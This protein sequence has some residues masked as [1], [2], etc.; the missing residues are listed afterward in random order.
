MNAVSPISLTDLVPALRWSKSPD[1]TAVLRHPRLVDGWWRSL[2]LPRVLDI[3]GPTWLAHCLARLSVEQWDHLEVCEFVPT[4]RGL[5]VDLAEIAEPVR[6][7]VQSTAGDWER[8]VHASPRTMRS[9]DFPNNCD[10]LEVVGTVMWQSILPFTGGPLNG[11]AP[12]PALVIE[13]VRTIANWM[14][15]SAPDHVRNAMAYLTEATGADSAGPTTDSVKGTQSP[16]TRAIRTLR[17]LR[18]QRDR[19]LA[20]EEDGAASPS[21]SP[22]PDP[23]EPVPLLAR[24][25]GSPLL[26]PGGTLRRPAF[27]PPKALR[28][29]S[30]E[31]AASAKADTSTNAPELGT[32]PLIDLFEQLCREWNDLERL[33]AT[34]RLFTAEPTSIRLL[35]DQLQMD[36]GAL[37]AAQRTVEE[38][39]LQWLNSPVGAPLAKHL[40][41]VSDQ[42]G[43]ATTIDLLVNAHPDHPVDVPSLGIP[44]WQIV[45]TLFTDRRLDDNWLLATD[46]GYLRR[47]T[48]QLLADQPSL[49]EAGTRL[50]RL[51]IRPQALRAWLLSTPGVSLQDGRVL[52]DESV[53]LNAAEPAG[54]YGGHTAF[55][56]APQTTTNGLPIRRRPAESKAAA[57]SKPSVAASARCFRAPDGRWWHRVDVT[58]DQLNGAPVAVPPGY[59]AHLGL[60]PGRLLCL[61]GPGADLLVLVWRDQAAF[62]SLRPLLRRLGAQPGDRLF[63]TVNGD[64]LDS[65]LLQ[66]SAVPADSGPLGLALSLTG[67]TAQATPEEALDIIARRISEADEGFTGT[68]AELLNLL[69]SRGD[70]DIAEQLRLSLHSAPVQVQQRLA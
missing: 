47:Q 64:R 50:G 46:T 53:P 22:A 39:L 66:A 61:T 6:G 37:R 25:G 65:R 19:E 32:H 54:G 24:R 62:D 70:E 41:E 15:A 42:L 7:A 28:D 14:P 56:A 18:A 68:P 34:E 60:Q 48:R 55:P 33:I 31:P 11:P 67:Y 58:A 63:I 36:I 44:L 26:G 9:W 45:M 52:V 69:S 5:T 38:R 49:S 2:P 20:A 10:V 51:G 17:A 4:L 8:L 43:V 12:S 27:G 3:A 13:A 23:K 57:E 16:A 21:P 30:R 29:Q 1:T 40:R 35:A 59:A